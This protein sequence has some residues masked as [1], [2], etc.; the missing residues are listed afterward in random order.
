MANIKSQEKR[1]RTNEIRR[2]RNKSVKSS[3]HTAIRGFRAAAAEG[4]KDKAGELLASTSRKLD[5]AASKGVI[6]KNQAANKKS[7]LAQAFNKI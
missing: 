2:V 5:K 3:L 1:I 7:A 6:H 4:D